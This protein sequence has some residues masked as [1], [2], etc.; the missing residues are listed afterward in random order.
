MNVISAKKVARTWVNEHATTIPGFRGAFFHGSANW[1]ADDATLPATSD[2]D[3][4]VVLASPEPAGKLGKFEYRGVLL[5]V[6]FLDAKLIG[7]PEIVLS[8]YRLAGSFW[9]AGA[10]LDPFGDLER[11][12][13][14]VARDFTRRRWV[15]ARC[16]D[17]EGNLRQ[18]LASFD[19]EGPF[20]AQVT[21]WLFATGV[22]THLLL[23]AGLKNPTVRTRY[24]AT[25]ELLA[26][27]GR[28]EFYDRLLTQLGCFE[29]A[30]ADVEGHL[31][32][33][34]SAFDAAQRYVS[35]SFPF[36]AD[37]SAAGRPV[38]ID[39]SRALIA[40]GDHREAIFWIAA[41]YARCQNVLQHDAPPE[42]RRQ[43][44]PGFR[45]LVAGL[46]IASTA[47]L[48]RR[49]RQ[50]LEFLPRVRSMAHAIMT[51]NPDIRPD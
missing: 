21:A 10:I 37:I 16:R 29:M 41:T 24:L 48:I 33:L 2:L 51:A 50:T 12:Q 1:L 25:R 40:R 27:Y 5:E 26:D 42:L 45:A 43:F 34:T 44:D 36:A 22:T 8:N 49:N 18:H 31:D 13:W 38:A 23:V 11:V 3:V 39:G 9:A 6:S 7:S 46:G 35:T 4:M 20:H 28:S 30:A 14:V 15:E 47:D 17:A 19:G 32:T